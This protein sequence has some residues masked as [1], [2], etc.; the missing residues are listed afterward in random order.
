MAYVE[1]KGYGFNLHPKAV[2]P[3][4]RSRGVTLGDVY[5]HW[6]C[7]KQQAYE[8]CRRMYEELDGWG[9]CI[10]GS[11]CMVF[12]V[13]FDFVNPETGEILR[14]IITKDYNHLYYL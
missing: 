7:A 3:N 4:P 13:K 6:S 9:F 1:I 2:A 14:T 5:G 12:T 11:N 10:T 8:Y